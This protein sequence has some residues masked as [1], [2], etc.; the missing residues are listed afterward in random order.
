[1]IIDPDVHQKLDLIRIYAESIL[2][3][4]RPTEAGDAYRYVGG[5]NDIE[6]LRQLIAEHH[7]LRFHSAGK[8]LA[9]VGRA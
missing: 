6:E 1:M 5:M 4:M 7:N 9:K 8:A 2:Q 3:N